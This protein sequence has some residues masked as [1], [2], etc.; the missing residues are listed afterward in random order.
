M[1]LLLIIKVQGNTVYQLI[2]IILVGS[3]PFLSF[4]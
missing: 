2:M 3:N 4:N 1:F